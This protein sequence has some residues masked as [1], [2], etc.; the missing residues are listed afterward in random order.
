MVAEHEKQ[1]QLIQEQQQKAMLQRQQQALQQQQQQA[2]QQQQA[3]QQ[4]QQQQQQLMM[5]QQ[6]QQSGPSTM[7]GSGM[8]FSM[9]APPMGSVG[10]GGAGSVQS[11]WLES[12]VGSVHYKCLALF[13]NIHVIGWKCFPSMHIQIRLMLSNSMHSDWYKYG[14]VY[15]VL[16]YKSTCCMCS[17]VS[18]VYNSSGNVC[19]S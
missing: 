7:P 10:L 6:L 18:A 4:Q 11:P 2:L 1:M 8:N 16:M 19:D 13:V 5:Q 12:K 9:G 14:N 3:M 15:G 17:M